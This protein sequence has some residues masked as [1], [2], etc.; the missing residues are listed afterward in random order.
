MTDMTEKIQ[1]LILDALLDKYE[2]SSFFRDEKEPTRRILLD[3]YNGGKSDFPYYDIEQSDRRITV[4][5]AVSDLALQ[6]LLAFEWM[7]GEQGHI[8]AK[9]WLNMDNLELAYRASGRVAKGDAVSRVCALIS[10]ARHKVTSAWACN[11]LDEAYTDISGKRKITGAIPNDETEREL[12]LQAIVAI[13]RLE[14]VELT[15]RVFS[16][17]AFGDSK[18]FEGKVKPRVIRILRKYLDTDD[19]ASDEDVLRLLGIVKYPE[20]LEFCGALSVSFDTNSQM[21]QKLRF[22]NVCFVVSGE[23][24]RRKCQRAL[25]ERLG[26]APLARRRSNLRPRGGSQK[27]PRL[28]SIS[29]RYSA[30]KVNFQPMRSGS[31]IY[32]SDLDAGRIMIDPAV[33]SV[34]TIEN[35]ANYVEY[36]RGCMAEDELVIYH[37]G[38][39]SPR[40]RKFLQT[41]A[42][43]MPGHCDWYHWSDIDYGGFLMLS[44][45]RRE[46][47][48]K[49]I[50]YRMNIDE[51]IRYRS[52][53]AKVE[54]QYCMKLERLKSRPELSDCIDCIDYMLKNMVRLEQEAMLIISD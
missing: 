28:R 35:R 2:R 31:V 52:L 34:I 23:A 15:E 9:V 6:N 1:K 18:I 12:L 47:C 29:N 37:G 17:R 10:E 7:K 45:I 14:G 25:G 16:M 49:A 30:G 41:V 39:Y 36:V 19:D 43:A 54:K 22:A 26:I 5:Q 11:F 27:P 24:K 4:N 50:P 8:I 33:K 20:Q 3:F 53:T 42:E 32:S 38:Q 40:K 46:I 48:P 44:R 21:K 51:L 13:D